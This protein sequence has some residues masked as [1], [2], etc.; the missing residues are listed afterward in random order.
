VD[1][2]A[3]AAPSDTAGSARDA[4]ISG[5]TTERE[6]RE[7]LVELLR[8][9]YAR[10]WVSGTGGGICGP[11]DGGGLLLAP[12]G[13]HKE[14][15]GVDDFFTVDPA[16]GRVLAA[17]SDA[18]LRPSECS[19]IFC[20]AFRERSARSVVHS[21]ALSAVL[22]GDLARGAD[23]VAIRDLEML[24]GV[25]GLGNRD[26]HL[27]P[28]VRNTAREPELVG[29]IQR[30]L[31]DPRFASTFAIVVADHGAYIWGDDVM[32]AKRHAEV[33]HFLFEA[34]VARH[35]RDRRLHEPASTATTK[36]DRA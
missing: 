30:V 13:V 21:H 22:A 36:E 26:V 31:D 34:T 29:D 15:V 25:R 19:S 14:R 6:T 23:H 9:F 1:V 5:V 4:T 10:N 3:A 24:K 20:L 7:L 18:A 28:V 16:D 35:D 12:T 17:P 32:E 8:G 11:A 33:Y 27:V 2:T